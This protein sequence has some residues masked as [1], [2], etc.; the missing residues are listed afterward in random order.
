MQNYEESLRIQREEGAYALHKR[1][2]SGNLAAFQTEKQ[3]EVGVAGANALGQ[4]G[5]NGAGSVDIGGS[6]TG[7]NPAAM[8]AGIA[9][10]GVVGKTLAGTM[11][12][13]MA[14]INHPT[15]DMTPP[16]I[17]EVAYNIASN[18]QA[19]GPYKIS[20]LVQLAQSGQINDKTLVWKPGMSSWSCI[21]SIE[22]LKGVLAAVP[23]VPPSKL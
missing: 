6:S 15:S 20:A 10:G 22:E 5:A 14:G 3:A 4:M 9:V 2:Q 13:A 17:P 16:P 12:N 7:F 1:T 8:M 18:G 21:D 23:P 19:T 11:Q